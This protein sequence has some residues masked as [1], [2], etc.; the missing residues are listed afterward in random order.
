VACWYDAQAEEDIFVTT[1][2]YDI[3]SRQD[4]QIDR[5]NKHILVA[6][7]NIIYLQ[8]FGSNQFRTGSPNSNIP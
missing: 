8:K 5:V 3:I 6:N 4:M 1:G 2:G 7:T